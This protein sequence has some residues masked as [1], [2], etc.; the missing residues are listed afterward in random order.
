[1]AVLSS[2]FPAV[3]ALALALALAACGKEQG[4]AALPPLPSLQTFVVQAAEAN[5]T[6][7][8]DGVIDAV[9]HAE[10]AAQTSGRVSEVHFDVN[11]RVPQKEDAAL[12]LVCDR[13]GGF[14]HV[15]EVVAWWDGRLEVDPVLDHPPGGGDLLVRGTLVRLVALRYREA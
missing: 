7:G 14:Q 1:M 8:W 9:R 2:K 10:L 6:R 4:A 5:S 13:L 12:S 3:T 15:D 11:D